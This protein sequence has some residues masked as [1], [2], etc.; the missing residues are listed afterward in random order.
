[1]RDGNKSFIYDAGGFFSTFQT[2]V[3]EVIVE[4]DGVDVR[5][6]QE[7]GEIDWTGAVSNHVED[8]HIRLVHELTAVFNRVEMSICDSGQKFGFKPGELRIA[9]DV[10]VVEVRIDVAST[11]GSSYEEVLPGLGVGCVIVQELHH[12][13]SQL[14]QCW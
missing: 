4:E 11:R 9:I 5:L 3:V 14:A 2:T 10:L 6:L 8:P 12:R 1:M 13:G 7:R